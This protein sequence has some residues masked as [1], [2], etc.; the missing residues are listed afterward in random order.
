[1]SKDLGEM[2]EN[3][4]EEVEN[5]KNAK[6]KIF[7]ITMT[8]TTIMGAFALVGS[9]LGAL[10]GSFEVYK[11]YMDMKDKLA[12]LDVEAI[13]VRNNEIEAKLDSAIEYTRDIKDGIR[14]D[15]LKLE[16]Q[17]DRVES[18]IDAAELRMKTT[19]KEIQDTLEMIRDDANELRK[20]VT[21]SIREVEA[22]NRLLE[23]DLRNQM[24]ETIKAIEFDMNQLEQDLNNMVQKALDNPLAD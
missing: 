9:I 22:N 21:N 7:G 6:M 4:E 14:E 11:D 20:D 1:M 15:L 10:Y 24:R 8:P 3:F 19:E 5:L 12:N 18:T 2:T 23:K 13:E 17:I 16:R